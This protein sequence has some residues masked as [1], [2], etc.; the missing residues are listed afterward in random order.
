MTLKSHHVSFVLFANDSPLW[1][2]LK[3]S[4]IIVPAAIIGGFLGGYMMH[5]LPKN[6][7][8]S[9]FLVILAAA[10]I[11]LLTVKS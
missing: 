5:K 1:I 10:A 2:S 3:I 6:V 4:A 8:R 11:R 7:V 9:V